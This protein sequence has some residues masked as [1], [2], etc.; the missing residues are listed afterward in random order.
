[1]LNINNITIETEY[2][3]TDLFLQKNRIKIIV[4]NIQ[5]HAIIFSVKYPANCQS[6]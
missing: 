2:I 6:K 5:I 4:V 1:M 3:F